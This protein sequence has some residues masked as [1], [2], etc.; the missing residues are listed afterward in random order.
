MENIGSMQM[1]IQNRH[2]HIFTTQSNQPHTE[3][4]RNIQTLVFFEEFFLNQIFDEQ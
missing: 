3:Y 2:I 4:K 1:T